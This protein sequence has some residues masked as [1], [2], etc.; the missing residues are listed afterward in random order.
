MIPSL[1]LA[2][3][4]LTASPD[5]LTHKIKTLDAEL[6]DAYNKCDLAKFAPLVAEFFQISA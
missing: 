3:Q 5:D 4:L 2:S 1:L 6:F